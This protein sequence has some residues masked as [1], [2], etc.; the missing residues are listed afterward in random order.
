M[1]EDLLDYSDYATPLQS[2]SDTFASL[3][4]PWLLIIGALF[5]LAVAIYLIRRHLARQ[6]FLH[7]EVF[8]IR[9]PRDLAAA[10]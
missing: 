7:H 1:N 2:S 3:L 6:Q 9:F 5:G 4:L 8:Q 10:R